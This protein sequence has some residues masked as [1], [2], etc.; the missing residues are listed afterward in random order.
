MCVVSK[1]SL[2]MRAKDKEYG[3]KCRHPCEF[4]SAY[5]VIWLLREQG[6]ELYVAQR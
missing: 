1:E 2:L 6:L 5:G 3:K 4:W